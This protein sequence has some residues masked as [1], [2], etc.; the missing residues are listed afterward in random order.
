MIFYMVCKNTESNSKVTDLIYIFY[1][2]RD[3]K[4]KLQM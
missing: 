4:K 3:A 1:F 2:F